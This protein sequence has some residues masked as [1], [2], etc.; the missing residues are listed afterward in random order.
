MNVVHGNNP[1]NLLPY[2]KYRGGGYI[3][4]SLGDFI[5]DYVVDKKYRNDL[6]M[7]VS[8]KLEK[9]G[10]KKIIEIGKIYP[11]II[12]NYQVHFF[13]KSV[14]KKYIFIIKKT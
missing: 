5:D 7:I 9:K 6:A 1:H 3:F 10:N 8:L 14:V 13:P 4:Y 11:I 12:K 2:E